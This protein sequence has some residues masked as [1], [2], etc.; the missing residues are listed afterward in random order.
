MDFR[1]WLINKYQHKDTPRGDLARDIIRDPDF[2]EVTTV[3]GRETILNHL[4]FAGASAE[5]IRTF[6]RAW[7]AYLRDVNKTTWK[8][9]YE[10]KRILEILSDYWIT[11]PDEKRVVVTMYFEKKDGQIQ[12]K[13]ITW[14]NSDMED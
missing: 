4:I 5:A 13:Q 12:E 9:T 8:N 10:Y 7:S 1:T 2:P 6:G 14:I 11:E 3:G